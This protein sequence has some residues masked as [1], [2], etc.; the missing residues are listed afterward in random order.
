MARAPTRRRS[1]P[2]P[3]A[4]IPDSVI[5]FLNGELG[6]PPGGWPEPFRTRALAGR[7]WKAPEATLS[8]EDEQA[9]ASDRRRTLNRLL[10]PPP[11]GPSTTPAG[12]YGDVAVLPTR[13]Y[14]YGLAQGEEHE[15]VLG[16]GVTLLLGVEAVGE[17]DERGFRTVMCTINGQ[18]RP[19]SVRDRSVAADVPAA[20][21]A[22]PRG[23]ARSP[24]P[25]R[26]SSPSPS[27]S[28]TPW[29]PATPWP[30]SR[31]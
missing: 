14:L 13:D 25:S 24:R 11:P 16:E 4:S 15:V 22:D 3:A 19:V 29:P 17:P 31:R 10:F 20:E 12:R 26:V 9:L 30:R 5:G 7:S 6:D 23:P 8:A 2:S 21:K 27:R 28:A 1:R 18:L